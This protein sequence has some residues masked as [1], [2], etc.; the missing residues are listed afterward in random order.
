MTD[1]QVL[2]N[3]IAALRQQLEQVEDLA[4]DSPDRVRRLERQ[5]AAGARQDALLHGAVAQLAPATPA[6]ATTLLPRQLTARARRI[7]EEGRS[8]LAR[9]RTLGAA[10]GQE[11]D[12]DGKAAD[13]ES[14]PAARFYHDT[15]AMAETA[16]RVVQTFP[17]APSAQLRLS[18]GLEAIFA[19][20][21]GRVAE[22]DTVVAQR[23][24]DEDRIDTLAELLTALDAGRA[25][26]AQVLS[27]LAEALVE[28]ARRGE[29]LRFLSGD[30]HQPARFVACHS[31]TTA[32]VIA[33][34]TRHDPEYRGRTQDPVLAALVH[35]VGMLAIG[36]ELLARPGP[37]DDA[38]RRLVE[39]HPRRGADL[40]GRLFPAAAWLL[41]NVAAHHERQ[42]GTGYP[43][44]LRGGQIGP[45]ALLLA[46]CDVYAALCTPRPHRPALDPRT[47]L[48]D[49]LLLAEQGGLDGALA[50]R[51]LHLAFY[52]VGSVVELTD[53]SVGV[54]VATH[55]LRRDLN[56]PARPV[57]ALLTDD[58]RKPLP[59]PRHVDLAQTDGPGIVRTLP[60][61]ER[62]ELLGGRYPSLA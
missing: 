18:D 37:L 26:D 20:V 59:A 33:R 57:L 47:A 10:L 44:G 53:G 6:P 23:R 14:P 52:P 48:T 16:L 38:G 45:L 61:A 3:K 11:A 2:L 9:L 51:L 28:E 41:E 13:L 29:P 31:L 49:T 54:V 17:D 4:G 35:D 22:L 34:L 62:R 15:V 7:L 58:E 56:A 50:E 55:P 8:L 24:R 21:A 27:D 12:P 5:V 25:T 32:Q 42:D 39:A 46:V 1:T 19:T 40:V 60:P 36:A 30:P 43:A